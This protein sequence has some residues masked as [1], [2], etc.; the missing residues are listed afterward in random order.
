MYVKVTKNLAK[1]PKRVGEMT[2]KGQYALI[3]QV[4]ADMNPYVPKL[5][6]DLR[7]QSTKSLDMKSIIYNAPYAKKQFYYPH[8][9]Y[10]TAG[11]GPRWDLKT[12]SIHS[13]SW[14]RVTKKAMK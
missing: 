8:R 14:E 11:T 9:N 3:N 4:H 5:R 1:V 10:T 12:K 6:G 2:K 7:N 13:G